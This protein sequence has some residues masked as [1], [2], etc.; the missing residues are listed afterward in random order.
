[1]FGLT[2][3]DE[4]LEALADVITRQKQMGQRIGTEL[5]EH[6]GKSDSR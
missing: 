4:G 5:D 6:N 3:Q 1:M 2:E